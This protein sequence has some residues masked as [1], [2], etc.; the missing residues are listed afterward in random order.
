VRM[1]FAIHGGVKWYGPLK[2]ERHQSEFELDEEQAK[3][4]GNCF[5]HVMPV[6]R[7]EDGYGLWGGSTCTNECKACFGYRT[8]PI[9]SER[10]TPSVTTRPLFC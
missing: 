3:Y 7:T 1:S 9:P 5:P 2:P 6:L 4:I 10:H 8:R